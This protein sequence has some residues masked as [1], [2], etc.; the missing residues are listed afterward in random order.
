MSP[1]TVTHVTPVEAD[2]IAREL[3]A[4]PVNNQ[5]GPF[6]KFGRPALGQKDEFWRDRWK[7]NP[8]RRQ[9]NIR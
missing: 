5:Q 6:I 4:K 1:C 8:A 2:R 3:G 9:S 7:V